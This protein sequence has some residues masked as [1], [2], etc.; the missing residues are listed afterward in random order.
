MDLFCRTYLPAVVAPEVL[1]HN[2]RSVQQQLTSMRFV[3]VEPT[4][5][6]TVVGIMT[7]GKSPADFIPGAYIQFL[8]IDGTALSDPIVDQKD[9]HGPLSELLRQLDE[10][11]KA[12][13]HIATDVQS[14][15]REI[16]KPDY[17][18]SALQQL[19]RNAVMHRDY[20]TSNAPV[21]LTWFQDRIE[22]QNPGGPFGQVTRENFG[23]PGITD[24][25]NPAIAAAM[26]NL[27]FVQR[28][29]VGIQIA[30]KALMDNDNPEP[31]FVVEENHVLVIVRKQL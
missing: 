11:V 4:L 7:I 28:F 8:R 31:E 16:R 15:S 13:I 17:P 30:R 19:L 21:R 6:P 9:I 2:Q 26:R 14:A 18:V 1:E 24:Y 23:Q 10:I 27:G 22:L 25:R 12:N 3:T 20:Q 5:V 29:G